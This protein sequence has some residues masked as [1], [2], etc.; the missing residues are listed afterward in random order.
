MAKAAAPVVAY[1]LC[2]FIALAVFGVKAADWWFLIAA[3][4]GVALLLAVVMLVVDLLVVLVFK[5]R[6]VLGKQYLQWVRGKRT[7]VGQ[8]PYDNI[9]EVGAASQT[10]EDPGLEISILEPARDD[11]WWPSFGDAGETR[12]LIVDEWRIPVSGIRSMI[13]RKLGDHS[14]GGG[15]RAS[16]NKVPCPSCGYRLAASV[17]VCTSCGYDFVTGINVDLT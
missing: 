10:P 5:P 4:G 2:M 17:V 9:R 14:A 12:A 11:T 3:L 8:I 16:D 1:G 7:I 15:A 13:I 6:L